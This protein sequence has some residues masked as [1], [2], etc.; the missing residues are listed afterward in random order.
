MTPCAR[1]NAESVSEILTL[2]GT[3]PVC[4]H[5]R[6]VVWAIETN[7]AEEWEDAA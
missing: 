2:A 6:E 5:C 1:C 4:E 7:R 3:I